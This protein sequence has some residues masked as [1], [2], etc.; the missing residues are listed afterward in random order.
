M[1]NSIKNTLAA[2]DTSLN[3]VQPKTMDELIETVHNVQ[4]AGNYGT[5]FSIVKY[6]GEVQGVRVYVTGRSKTHQLPTRNRVYSVFQGLEKY[7]KAGYKVE[8]N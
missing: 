3:R 8:I 5:S 4:G 2:I 1:Q 6:M 7:E